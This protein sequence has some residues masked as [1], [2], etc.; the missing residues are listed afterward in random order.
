MYGLAG[1]LELMNRRVLR[2]FGQKGIKLF[3]FLV[4]V[5]LRLPNQLKGAMI[6]A[7]DVIQVLADFFVSLIDRSA[8]YV[9]SDFG[10]ARN[11]F[12]EYLRMTRGPS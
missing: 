3:L 9:T 12:S 4:E 6:L 10:K 5:F 8:V 11:L 1:M 2:V 7:Q